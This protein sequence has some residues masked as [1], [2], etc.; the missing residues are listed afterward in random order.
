MMAGV[1]MTWQGG[2]GLFMTTAAAHV[3][4]ILFVLLRISVRAAVK[5]ADKGEF[6]SIPAARAATPETAAL[7]VGE[8]GDEAATGLGKDGTAPDPA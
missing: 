5:D 4:L 8:A 3:A 6:M 2:S 7:A 1:A